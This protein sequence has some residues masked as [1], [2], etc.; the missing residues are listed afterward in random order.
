MSSV[1]SFELSEVT[2][3]VWLDKGEI[4]LRRIK[5]IGDDF[6]AGYKIYISVNSV[7]VI[8]EKRD[9]I[10]ET[11]LSIMKGDIE[12]P[13]NIH[14]YKQQ[15]LR[16]SHFYDNF[17]FGLHMLD[18]NGKVKIGK[19]M[20]LTEEEYEK[21]LKN[22]DKKV[23]NDCYYAALQTAPTPSTS[24]GNTL[25]RASTSL[26]SFTS[27]T[28]K[29]APLP[30]S[31][32]AVFYGWKWLSEVGGQQVSDN[33]TDGLWHACPKLCFHEA[34]AFK[35]VDDG[36]FV[37]HKLDVF[38]VIEDIAVDTDFMDA[39]MVKII[40]KKIAEMVDQDK[41]SSIYCS[42]SE[43][44]EDDNILIYGKTALDRI[45]FG[46][47]YDNCVHILV[48]YDHKPQSGKELEIMKTVNNYVKRDSIIT[49]MTVTTKFKPMLSAMIDYVYS[50]E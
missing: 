11:V 9:E 23:E 2:Q 5:D 7:R 48:F 22:V 10:Q 25:K 40:K 16:L 28:K 32:P 47:L 12:S 46:E 17:Y 37:Q 45:T 19:G 20:N 8:R 44:E 13:Y 6:D 39:V 42:D 3:G 35:P 30:L 29:A 27:S 31:I 38:T 34:M 49:D 4:Q 15:V 18:S 36:D 33:K 26:P 43:D 1:T 41:R 14:L 21:L 24:G 50:L